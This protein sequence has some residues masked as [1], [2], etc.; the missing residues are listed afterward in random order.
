VRKNLIVVRAGDKSLHPTWLRGFCTRTFDV[1]VSYYGS[2][3][4]QHRATADFY[5]H[6]P[7]PRW[8]AQAHLCEQQRE[9]IARYDYVAFV[10][11][12]LAARTKTWNALFAH[13]KRY[14]LD[15]AQP[16]I[17]GPVS[18]AITRP[19]K[20]CVLRYTNFVEIMCPVFHRPTLERLQWTL[21]ES[22]SGWGLDFLWAH[23]SPFP[24]HR[25]A[26]I[27]A[28]TVRHTRPVRAGNLYGTLARQGVDP[29][30]EM[31]MVLAKHHVP[32]PTMVE[33]D[34]IRSRGLLSQL[35]SK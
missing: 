17:V 7:G 26:V 14:R 29:L 8:P 27:D 5:H 23:L 35:W 25:L 16:A 13:C 24:D 12:D 20:G 4:D 28:V 6:E 22:K 10:A 34:R 32:S 33:H 18:H 3:P 31:K 11:D 1:Y 21:A 15:L 19:A 9:L 30:D 2:V